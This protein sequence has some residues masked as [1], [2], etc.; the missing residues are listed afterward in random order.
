[1]NMTENILWQ[2]LPFAALGVDDLYAILALRQEV[3]VV[4]QR[5]AYLDC[6]GSD[7]EALHLVGWSGD[8]RSRRPLAYLRVLPPAGDGL[9][10]RIGRLLTHAD[11]RHRGVARDMLRLAI[12]RLETFYPGRPIAISAQ[13]YLLGFYGRF[14]FYATSPPYLEDGIPHVDMIRSP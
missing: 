14:G 8:G 1:M 10:V 7:Q 9:P 13:Q 2:W 11:I 6:D 4:E 5:C 3:F 12:E